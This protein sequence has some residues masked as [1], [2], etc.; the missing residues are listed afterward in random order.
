MKRQGCGSLRCFKTKDSRHSKF[1]Y[2]CIIYIITSFINSETTALL[3]LTSFTEDVTNIPVETGRKLNVHKTFNLYPVSTGID[4]HMPTAFIWNSGKSSAHWY[5]GQFIGLI[6]NPVKHLGIR[7]LEEIVNGVVRWVTTFVKYSMFLMFN[8]RHAHI[9]L[10]FLKNLKLNRLINIENQHKSK[11]VTKGY[12]TF[13]HLDHKYALY[14]I[15]HV[16]TM[17]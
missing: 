13:T 15:F 3:D 8:F 12:T 5:V 17:K 7:V 9:S 6:Q 2:T 4:F 1:K 10:Q 16:W 14:S 11:S